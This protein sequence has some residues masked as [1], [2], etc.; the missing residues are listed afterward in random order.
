M[1]NFNFIN[2]LSEAFN[3]LNYNSKIAFGTFGKFEKLI[4]KNVFRYVLLFFNFCDVLTL[5]LVNREFK[6]FIDATS[7]IKFVFNIKEKYSH[8]LSDSFFLTLAFPTIKDLSYLHK[9]FTQMYL[10]DSGSKLEEAYK[11]YCNKIHSTI[12]TAVKGRRNQIL[13]HI[14]YTPPELQN[15][16]IS[17]FKQLENKRTYISRIL[18]SYDFIGYHYETKDGFQ[19]EKTWKGY[20]DNIRYKPLEHRQDLLFANLYILFA[21]ILY[22]IGYR[23]YRRKYGGLSFLDEFFTILPVFLI[24][25]IALFLG[26]NI[27]LFPKATDALKTIPE[28]SKK[29]PLDKIY[30]NLKGSEIICRHRFFNPPPKNSNSENLQPKYIFQKAIPSTMS[31]KVA[32]NKHL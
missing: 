23:A 15:L 25:L 3:R 27:Y 5:R 7:Q 20:Y 9:N 14:Y 4:S 21:C 13:M 6:Y 24:C 17:Y 32:L 10:L 22:S 18:L 31:Q 29:W 28:E 30:S 12:E 8:I 1:L 19:F 16:V 2:S 11:N 26:L